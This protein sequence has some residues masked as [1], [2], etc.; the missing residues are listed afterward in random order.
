MNN[1]EYICDVCSA[2]SDD[3]VTCAFCGNSFCGEWPL[4]RRKDQGEAMTTETK[5]LP[6]EHDYQE[7]SR[8]R[9]CGEPR[10]NAPK[11]PEAPKFVDL[12]MGVPVEIRPAP[13]PEAPKERVPDP[14]CI[15]GEPETP[16][17][18]HSTTGPCFR[19]PAPEPKPCGI[20]KGA[21][22]YNTVYRDRIRCPNLCGDPNPILPTK[23][24]EPQGS[25]CP[26]CGHQTHGSVCMNFGSDNECPC[27]AGQQGSEEP[28][29]HEEESVL[30]EIW[31][32]SPSLGSRLRMELIQRSRAYLALRQ[33]M[34][35]ANDVVDTLNLQIEDLRAEL[36]AARKMAPLRSMSV[37]RLVSELAS[38]R[39]EIAA[40]KR[41]AEDATEYVLAVDNRELRKEIEGL[42]I[43]VGEY[44]DMTE[45]NKRFSEIEAELATVKA[46]RDAL[47]TAAEDVLR[48]RRLHGDIPDGAT[49][50]RNA[51]TRAKEGEKR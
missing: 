41:Q 15:C 29:D 46:E 28:I 50:L 20:C 18:V 37:E 45:I 8:C 13:A 10:P 40:I 27:K 16:N 3:V 30:A 26:G 35:H 51:L 31:A 49:A 36:A 32:S 47:A 44:E 11:P 5:C 1:P 33:E 25:V 42:R 39:D 4:L 38:A 7:F 19:A 12:G 9:M 43:R 48:E 23:A 22:F 2:P 34:N 21:G 17:V 6:G 24:P 14:M